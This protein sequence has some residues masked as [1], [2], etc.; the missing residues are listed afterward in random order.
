MALPFAPGSLHD[1]AYRGDLD[2][3]EAA[4]RRESRDDALDQ[5][6]G[7]TGLTVLHAA[8]SGDRTAAC[9]AL[10]KQHGAAVDRARAKDGGPRPKDVRARHNIEQADVDRHV[11]YS[12]TRG[13]SEW[14]SGAHNYSSLLK[15]GAADYSIHSECCKGTTHPYS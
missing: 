6:D 7:R 14:R 1:L 13:Y 8:A 12:S 3:L 9:F 2:E 10:V 5:P 4:L 15:V 11:E